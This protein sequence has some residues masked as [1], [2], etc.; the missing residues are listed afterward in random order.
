M[1][2]RRLPGRQ[3][4]GVSYQL[5]KRDLIKKQHK[6]YSNQIDLLDLLD[7]LDLRDLRDLRDLPLA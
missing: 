6:N 4:T 2:G 5:H 7:L 3:Q 1:C